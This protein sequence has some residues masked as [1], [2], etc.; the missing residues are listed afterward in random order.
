MIQI[1][2]L[3]VLA[4]AAFQSKNY[5]Q[6][7]NYYT[8]I[9]EQNP[10]SSEAW[11]KKGLSSGFMSS[12]DGIRIDECIYLVKLAISKSIDQSSRVFAADKLIDIYE[13]TIRVLNKLLINAVQNHQN[14]P[15]I[16]GGSTLLHMV[17]Q[18]MIQISSAK[19]QSEIKVR[20]LDLVVLSVE[21]DASEGNYSALINAIRTLLTHASN[22]G[23]Y[24]AS[25]DSTGLL[26]SK[27]NQL[28]D[29]IYKEASDNY[30]NI[31]RQLAAV[32]ESDKKVH[33]QTSGCFIATAAMGTY[34]HPKVK[35]LRDFR[36]LFLEKSKFGQV[37]ITV[38]Y[39]FSPPIAAFIAARPRLRFLVRLS[40]IEPASLIAGLLLKRIK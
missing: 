33:S 6:A 26:L 2:T 15:M 35:I 5:S 8:Q 40:I 29:K 9:L 17:G 21:L 36:D 23:N 12:S 1:N 39:R 37:F 20:A 34:T 3:E 13:H 18:S 16:G 22:N 7:Y 11:L 24:L 10:D 38:Y 30:P 28:K 25:A 4:E 32:Q 19:S 14:I 31:K 27:V